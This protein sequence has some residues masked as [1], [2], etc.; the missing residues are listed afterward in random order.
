MQLIVT[1]ETPASALERVGAKIKIRSRY[2]NFIGGEW[3]AR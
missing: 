3:V 1:P 2:D